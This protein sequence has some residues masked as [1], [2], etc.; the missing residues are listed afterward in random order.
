MLQED[1]QNNQLQLQVIEHEECKG[2]EEDTVLSFDN[3]LFFIDHEEKDMSTPPPVVALEQQANVEEGTGGNG[4]AVD[5]MADGLCHEPEVVAFRCQEEEIKTKRQS[6]DF[7]SSCE[8]SHKPEICADELD[9]NTCDYDVCWLSPIP[10]S[11]DVEYQ[12]FI[13]GEDVF[14]GIRND[15]LELECFTWDQH[16]KFDD[17]EQQHV[18][19]VDNL[20]VAPLD[21]IP[22]LQSVQFD[23]SEEPPC[24]GQDRDMLYFSSPCEF[25][26]FSFGFNSSQEEVGYCGKNDAPCVKEMASLLQGVV[27]LMLADS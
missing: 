9:I 10:E 16:T 14:F 15:V 12:V 27:L 2:K 1:I 3:L 18:G 25:E 19:H 22:E 17:I 7:R 26:A 11:D 8:V 24:A 5:C 21:S 6:Q 13:Q 4:F 20:L 23:V